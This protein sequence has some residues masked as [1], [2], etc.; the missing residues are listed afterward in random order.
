MEHIAAVLLI[1]GCS[2]SLEQCREL[3]APVSVFETMAECAGERRLAIRNLTQG[4]Q[5]VFS[6]CLAVDPALEDEY[7]TITWKV[8]ADGAFEASLDIASFTVASNAYRD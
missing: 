6:R 4:G 5:R 8:R 3:P 2:Q 7:D 1:V